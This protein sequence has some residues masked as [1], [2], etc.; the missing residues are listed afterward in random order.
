MMP[1][2][3][4]PR[5]DDLATHAQIQ[6]A[7]PREL[8]LRGFL[9][10]CWTVSDAPL[11]RAAL[12]ASDAHLR[13]W[14]PWVLDGRVPGQ[15]LEQRL[16]LHAA[17]FAQGAQWVYGLFSCDGGEVLGGCGLYPR[18]GPNALELGYWLAAGHTG[19]GLATRSSAELTRLAFEAPA[20]DRVEIRCERRNVASAKVPERLGYRLME[21]TGAVPDELMVWRL[22]RAELPAR[23]VAPR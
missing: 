14:T 21:S 3:E 1:E 7:P 6:L 23:L 20:V 5:A 10:R 15:T 16:A 18:V 11:L 9:L 22:M 12:A 13:E 4:L 8:E 19:R 17:D 2:P